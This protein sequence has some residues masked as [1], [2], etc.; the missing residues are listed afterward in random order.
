VIFYNIFHYFVYFE[1]RSYLGR[2][3]PKNLFWFSVYHTLPLVS[4]KEKEKM[5]I[6]VA[7]E[8]KTEREIAKAVHISLKYIGRI[9]RKITGD[10]ETPAEKEKEEDE[11]K[12]K[13]LK[14]IPI[15]S[16]L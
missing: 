7:N 5:V 16:G 6:K 13:R 14:S 10:D 3:I 8:G 15:C 1:F 12:Q 9:L 4:S 11:K 2:N